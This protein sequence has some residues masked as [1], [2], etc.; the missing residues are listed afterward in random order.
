MVWIYRKHQFSLITKVKLYILRS[1]SDRNYILHINYYTISISIIFQPSIF[2]ECLR[3]GTITFSLRIDKNHPHAKIKIIHTHR[4]SGS[5][6]RNEDELHS[7]VHPIEIGHGSTYNQRIHVHNN[8]R[9]GTWACLFYMV[10][11]NER[12]SAASRAVD[13]S[14]PYRSTSRSLPASVQNGDADQGQEVLS[15][16]EDRWDLSFFVSGCEYWIGV[17]GLRMLSMLGVVVVCFVVCAVWMCCVMVLRASEV[18][19]FFWKSR[20]CARPQY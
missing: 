2:A 17:S 9:W 5:P 18:C 12:T 7:L 14:V 3:Y 13:T 6:K 8:A 4:K 15:E 20:G 1:L 19:F 11:G 16:T 10:E